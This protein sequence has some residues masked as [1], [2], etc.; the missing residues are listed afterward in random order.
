MREFRFGSD[1]FG[2]GA[3]AESASPLT[4]KILR[5]ISICWHRSDQQVGLF[6]GDSENQAFVFNRRTQASQG[7]PGRYRLRGCSVGV[8]PGC[9]ARGRH[10]YMIIH[11]W[12]NTIHI[13]SQERRAMSTYHRHHGLEISHRRRPRAQAFAHC[14]HVSS[15]QTANQRDKMAETLFQLDCS[16]S[17]LSLSFNLNSACVVVTIL[18]TILRISTPSS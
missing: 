12:N 14:A 13:I 17:E 1:Y 6:Q 18:V 4:T 9:G 5:W 2:V 15:Q 8:R 3:Y 7:I 10:L 11:F 16:S